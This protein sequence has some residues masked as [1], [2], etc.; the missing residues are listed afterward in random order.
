MRAGEFVFPDGQSLV[1]IRI[2]VG[3]LGYYRDRGSQFIRLNRLPNA[4]LTGWFGCV[5]P[6]ASGANTSLFINVG[7]YY[8][9]LYAWYNLW[10]HNNVKLYHILFNL[11]LTVDITV[12]IATFG[13]NISGQLYSLECSAE[14][15]GSTDQVNFTWL[16]P[17]NDE[18]PFEMINATDS[19]STLIFD[20]L[21]ISHAGTYSCRVTLGEVEQKEILTVGVEG[22]LCTRYW[23]FK[24]PI[25]ATQFTVQLVFS[26]H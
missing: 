6:D 13:T 19:T 11:P 22:K 2:A 14:V 17:A 20:P 9:S 12:S 1:P 23:F 5:I 18:V 21:S 15:N 26:Y 25:T 8:E 4:T 24:C 16:D 3:V 7:R 10:P